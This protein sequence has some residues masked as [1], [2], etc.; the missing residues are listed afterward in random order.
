MMG[1]GLGNIGLPGL[2]LI[3]VVNLLLV[4][5]FWKILPRY[6]YN[7]YLSLLC[8]IPWI[9]GVAMII[10]L[11]LIALADGEKSE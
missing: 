1:M 6:G 2:L 4:I 7:K 8:M 11:W 9:G 3:I 10:Y 5:P